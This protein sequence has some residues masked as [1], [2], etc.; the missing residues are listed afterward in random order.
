MPD[1]LW[2]FRNHLD[3]VVAI[4]LLVAAVVVFV[5]AQLK[6]LPSTAG[7]YVVGAL[8]ALAGFELFTAWRASKL[9]APK[10]QLTLSPFCDS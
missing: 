7:K 3:L 9:E 6:S 4:G 1:W 10:L 5:L 2:W 8:C